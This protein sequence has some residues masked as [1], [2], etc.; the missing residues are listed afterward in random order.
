MYLRNVTALSGSIRMV[1][2]KGQENYMFI[3]HPVIK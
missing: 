2:T 3:K 1:L